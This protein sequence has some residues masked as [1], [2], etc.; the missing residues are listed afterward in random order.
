MSCFSG[1][2]TIIDKQHN[3]ISEEMAHKVYKSG[4][5]NK[6]DLLKRHWNNS[7]TS[8]Y[9]LITYSE[10]L[11]PC[12]VKCIRL[13]CSLASRLNIL[14]SATYRESATCPPFLENHFT[15]HQR[16]I[17]QFL[18]PILHG[19]PLPPFPLYHPPSSFLYPSLIANPLSRCSQSSKVGKRR[20][21]RTVTAHLLYCFA[22]I[23]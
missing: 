10:A 2:L 7:K 18:R 21:E 5:L 22:V 13:T 11:L 1:L 8:E 23:T 14:W 20:L 4:K 17:K 12:T 19:S 16:S 6:I 9:I 3:T 15:L